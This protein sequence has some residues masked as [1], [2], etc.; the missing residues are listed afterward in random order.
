MC[1]SIEELL[2]HVLTRLEEDY[3]VPEY[4]GNLVEQVDTSLCIKIL[5]K[6]KIKSNIQLMKMLIKESD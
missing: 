5:L 1:F 4:S 6:I 3:N 2:Q